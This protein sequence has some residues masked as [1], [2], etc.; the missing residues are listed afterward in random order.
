MTFPVTVN[1][2]LILESGSFFVQ[3][4]NEIREPAPSTWLGAELNQNPNW[5]LG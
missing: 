4:L 1:L 2:I 5:P 3:K